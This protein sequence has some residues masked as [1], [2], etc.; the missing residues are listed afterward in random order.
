[1]CRQYNDYG[2]LQRDRDDRNLNS[3]NFPEF[4]S[5]G[6]DDSDRS[7]KD[8]LFAIAEYERMGLGMAMGRLKELT[9]VRREGERLM[10]AVELFVDVTDVYGQIYVLRDIDGPVGA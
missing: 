7:L 8:E 5:G 3:V 2:S 1:M 6:G 10:K 9:G 4:V